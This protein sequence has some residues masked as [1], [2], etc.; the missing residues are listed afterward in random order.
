MT[1]LTTPFSFDSIVN[2][3]LIQKCGFSPQT[4][5]QYGLVVQSHIDFFGSFAFPDVA[6]LGLRV[7]K[8]GK[9]S[10]T[11]EIGLFVRGDDKVKA[12]GELTHVFVDRETGRPAEKG[13]SGELR[14]ELE[15]ILFRD[16]SSRL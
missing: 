13:L 1:G 16:V 8:L 6:E 14:K 12:V 3:F 4:S 7:K 10:V 9:A 5:P 11:Y 15:T 2:S